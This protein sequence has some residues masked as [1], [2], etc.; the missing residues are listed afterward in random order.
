MSALEAV[1]SDEVQVLVDN[2]SDNLSSVPSLVETEFAA[3]GRRRHGTVGPDVRM[4]AG[5]ST[6]TAQLAQR[7]QENELLDGYC[8]SPF[9]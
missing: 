6:L 4:A 2:I 1:E 5:K 7:Q 3:L 9:V 8:R